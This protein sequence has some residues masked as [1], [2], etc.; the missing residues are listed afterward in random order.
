MLECRSWCCG[1]GE[2]QRWHSRGSARG[3][4]LSKPEFKEKG[5]AEL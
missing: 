4:L 5:T 2:E 3:D 1:S